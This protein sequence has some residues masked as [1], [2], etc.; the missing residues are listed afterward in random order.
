MLATLDRLLRHAVDM[1]RLAEV[2]K[3]L[4]H[5]KPKPSPPRERVLTADEETQL[6]EGAILWL[7]PM[8]QIA[9]SQ[10]LR[11]GEVCALRWEDVDWD[12]HRLH[13]ARALGRR[14]TEVGPTKGR[15]AAAIV[16]TPAARAVL[17]EAWMAAG[18]PAEG[19]V[20]HTG[21]VTP[22]GI[23]QV[24]VAYLKAV[25][26]AGLAGDGVCF[27]TLRHTALTRAG[28]RPGMTL[29]Y[30]QQFARH[31]NAQITVRYLH[32]DS[33]ERMEQV[34][35][36]ERRAWPGAAPVEKLAAEYSR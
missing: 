7:R 35:G 18:R 16:L 10:A 23:K 29:D 27:H 24:S 2:P 30:L 6:R 9:L 34:F 31:A 5:R 17:L 11:I 36:I 3:L 15:K 25:K 12:R 21:I 1:A 4:R 33:E 32:V 19:W 13:V 8:V 26:A 28:A 20:F 22:R 14:S